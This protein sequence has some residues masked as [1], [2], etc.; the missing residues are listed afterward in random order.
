MDEQTAQHRT[1]VAIIIYRALCLILFFVGVSG[2]V[3]GWFW[4]RGSTQVR[5]A[6]LSDGSRVELLGTAV[7]TNYFSNDQPWQRVA[8]RYLPSRLARRWLPPTINGTARGSPDSI[9]IYVRITGP[10]AAPGGA[11][12]WQEYGAQDTNGFLYFRNGG[13]SA[14][15]VGPGSSNWVTVFDV[16]S[17]PRRQPEFLLCFYTNFTGG[18]MS[19]TLR[20]PNPMHGPFPEWRPVPLPQTI[21]NGPVSLALESLQPAGVPGYSYIRPD[22]QLESSDPAWSHARVRYWTFRDATGNEGAYLSPSEPAAGNST[23]RFI[24]KRPGRFRRRQRTVC[25]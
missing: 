11:K 7:G 19:A 24:V 16:S 8:R 23:Q 14:F 2:L 22:W 20:V 1:G 17:Y 12:P 21:T 6:L 3:T 9:N 4:L 15:G 5:V 13:Y 10:A 18:A 25:G